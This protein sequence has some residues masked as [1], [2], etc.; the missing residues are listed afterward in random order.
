MVN[1]ISA[2]KSLLHRTMRLAKMKSQLVQIEPGT[3]MNF[4][5]PTDPKSEKPS[6]LLLHGFQANAIFTWQFQ[7]ISLTSEYNVYAP[8]FLFFGGS[9]TDSDE[10]T[11]DFQAHCVA[12]GLRKLGVEKCVVVGFSYGGMVGFKLA[13]LY[14]ELVESFVVNNSVLRLTESITADCLKRIGLDRWDDF[15]LPKTVEAMK[16]T[17]KIASYKLPS[18]LPNFFFKDFFEVMYENRQQKAELIKALVTSDEFTIPKFPQR[19]HLLWGENDKIFNTDIA[20]NLLRQ[21]GDEGTI[22]RRIEKA[23]HV[24]LLERPCNYNHHLRNILKSLKDPR[25]AN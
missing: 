15:L 23:G 14:P 3:V 13:E 1:I 18:W 24:A 5:G 4:W 22:M 25:A 19:I 8:D 7:I 12:N 6:I 11:T 21:V 16:V 20:Q 17:L 9:Y 2:Y 10:R